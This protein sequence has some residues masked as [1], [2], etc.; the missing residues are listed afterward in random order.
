M[1]LILAILLL[2]SWWF[3]WGIFH[4]AGS[5][6]HLALAVGIGILVLRLVRL[7]DARHP[8]TAQ[9]SANIEKP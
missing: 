7:S 5:G 2:V 9:V 8:P 1:L 6:I 3:L 4:L